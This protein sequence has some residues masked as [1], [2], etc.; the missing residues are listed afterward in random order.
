[1][2]RLPVRSPSRDPAVKAAADPAQRE[3]ANSSSQPLTR[4]K[5]LGSRLGLLWVMIALFALFSIWLPST[6]FTLG[7][8]QTMVNSQS[9]ILMLAIAA[10]VPLRAGDFDFSI[11]AVMT[12]STATVVVLVSHGQSLALAVLLA[13]GV[14]LVVG[15]INTLLIVMVGVDSLITTLGLLTALGG[16]A[17]A[18]TNSNV[19]DL[20]QSSAVLGFA[21]DTIA[22]FPAAT[23]YAWILVVIAWYVYE[24]TP[25]G[26]YLIFIGGNRDAARLAGVRVSAVRGF[27]LLTSALLSAFAGVVLAGQLGAIDPSIGSQYLLQPFAAALLGATTVT[28]G[29][30]NALGTLVAL[31]LLVIGVT[32]L[33][34]LGASSWANDVFNGLALVVAVT[35]AKLTAGSQQT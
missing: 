15:T 12:A 24:K 8:V 30:A 18:I 23:W 19:I 7:N 29:R 3:S 2:P 21:R 25:L 28:I 5:S 34:L 1:M 32:G 26:R 13:L 6:F 10:T 20:P 4:L 11:A 33:E 17:Y 35:V 14:G 27:A 31:Y 9:V 22:G 16:Y